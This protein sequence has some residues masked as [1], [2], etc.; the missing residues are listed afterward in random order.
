MSCMRLIAR[1]RSCARHVGA[2]L[3]GTAA[4]RSGVL[5]SALFG[6]AMFGV[7]LLLIGGMAQDVLAQEVATELG[8]GPPSDDAGM[9]VEIEVRVGMTIVAPGK[10]LAGA[11]AAIVAPGEGPA[12]A[13]SHALASNGDGRVLLHVP[14]SGGVLLVWAR[15][16]APY[17]TW[18]S[19]ARSMPIVL[20]APLRLAVDVRTPS[21]QP[22]ANARVTTIVRM[23]IAGARPGTPVTHEYQITETTDDAGHAVLQGL[24]DATLRVRADAEGFVGAEAFPVRAGKAPLMLALR[25]GATVEGRAW[26]IPG[27]AA[28]EGI[29]LRVGERETTVRA[30]GTWAIDAIPPGSAQV[31]LVSP[32]LLI[33]S[34]PALV[35]RDGERRAGIDLELMRTSILTGRLVD[36]DEQP[37]ERASLT[38]LWPSIGTPW[39]GLRMEFEDVIGPGDAGAFRLTGL[40]PADGIAL[41]IRAPGRAPRIV[42]GIALVPNEKLGP[43]VVV[44]GRGA[45]IA[46]RVTDPGGA[47]V[48]GARVEARPIG[49]ADGRDAADVAITGP[50]GVFLLDGL[51][52]V[53]VRLRVTPPP[54]APW[55]GASFGPF[56]PGAETATRPPPLILPIGHALR[57]FVIGAPPRATGV[58]EAANGEVFSFALDAGTF[59]VAGLPPGDVYIEILDADGYGGARADARVPA[60]WP[61]ELKWRDAATVQLRL[62][63]RGGRLITRAELIAEPRRRTGDES[64]NAPLPRELSSAEGS[65]DGK[66]K[67]ALEPGR[68]RVTARAGGLVGFA[69][70]DV[71]PTSGAAATIAMVQGETVSGD[72]ASDDGGRPVEGALVTVTSFGDAGAPA[73]TTLSDARGHFRIEGIAPGIVRV[74][75]EARGHATFLSRPQAVQRAASL[76]IGRVELGPGTTLIGV[77]HDAAGVPS[78]G[79]AIVFVHDAGTTVNGTTD[80][81]G[82]FRLE[83]LAPGGGVVEVAGRSRRVDLPVGTPETRIEIDLGDGTVLRGRATT[84]G[85][86]EAFARISAW[87]RISAGGQSSEPIEV[88]THADAQ[89]RFELPPLPAGEIGIEVLAADAETPWE[90]EFTLAQSANEWIDLELPAGGVSGAV[91]QAAGN[92]VPGARVWLWSVDAEGA[93]ERVVGRTQTVAEGRFRIDRIPAGR[94]VLEAR[95]RGYGEGRSAVFDVSAGAFS[96][97]AEIRLG[98]ESVLAGQI[99]DGRGVPVAE[100][101]I[102]ATP[103]EDSSVRVRIRVRAGADGRVALHSLTPGDYEVAVG[104]PGRGRVELGVLRL[105]V[106][107]TDLGQ[108]TLEA[109]G[110][111]R[112]TV[113]QPGYVP[114]VGERVTL[115]DLIGRT[116][117]PWRDARDPTVS[118]TSTRLRVTDTNGTVLVPDLAPGLYLISLADVPEPTEFT[119][120]V[121]AGE[122]TAVSLWAPPFT[123]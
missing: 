77:V 69:E 19:G 59:D 16:H 78:R 96:Y 58:I 82:R 14:R 112:I 31:E 110:A 108:L 18:V 54:G 61:L 56:S 30:D 6:A 74:K 93:L 72:V 57:G 5:G 9:D 65:L 35:L 111:L 22:A 118:R 23:S 92:G 116:P 76:D 13:A 73:A 2:N 38:L 25:R 42:E 43:L 102:S 32:N 100:G 33:R 95:R 37:I 36:R 64:D 29:R 80:L 48:E 88:R 1:I 40:P 98:D 44:M 4:L 86:P 90:T 122:V 106:G 89:G 107:T 50:G 55:R 20:D 120:R 8:P 26:L 101:W 87:V 109:G 97:G 27:G 117:E 7:G 75:I 68:W 47:A 85:R 114:A 99:V 71:D 67:L 11:W 91:L 60:G 15:D 17:A 46:G 3:V 63:G 119:V 70:V 49:D 10:P 52:A 79:A 39:S 41:E 81:H 104:G 12:E 83:Y 51:P 123:D 34:V 62:E 115:R 94:F 113:F 21:A 53:P 103:Y 121:R 66:F 84:D 105:T 45:L 28:A 24:P